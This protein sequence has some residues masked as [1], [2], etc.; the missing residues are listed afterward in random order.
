MLFSDLAKFL[1]DAEQTSGRNDTT[2]KLAGFLQQVPPGEIAQVMYLLQGRLLP[3]FIDLEFGFS[4]KSALKALD[5]VAA[6]VDVSKEYAESGDLGLVAAHI[7]DQVNAQLKSPQS[8]DQVYADLMQLAK[9][10]GKGSQES[11]QQIYLSLIQKADSE[12]ARY[13]TR[14]VLGSLRTGFSD[15]TILD[16]LSWVKS[17]NKSW[18]KQLDIAYGAKAD[19]G[20]LAKLVLETDVAALESRLQQI[21]LTPGVPVAS[22]LV[23]REA[24]AAAV[25]ARMGR[26]LV[27]PK[28]DGLRCQIHLLAEP[29]VAGHRVEI[30]SRNME[31]LTAVFPDVV[32]AVQKLPVQSLIIDSEAIGYDSAEEAYLPFQ[33]TIQRRRKYDI[34][35]TVESIPIRAMAFDLIY[36]DGEDVS[37][38]DVEWRVAQLQQIL[39]GNQQEVICLLESK[40][41][42]TE[43]ELDNYFRDKIGVGLE[44]IIVKRLGTTYDPGTRNFDWIK[45]KA[46]TQSDM[47]DTVDAVVL[48]YFHGRGNRAQF[49]VGALL[50]GVYNSEDDKYYST[51]KIGTG[52]TEAQLAEIFADLQPLVVAT[53]P[54]NVQVA[55][56][57]H[58][59]V[60][61]S[62]QIVVEVDA[63]E[64]TRSPGHT[65][66]QGT[67]A[68]FE[69]QP[70]PKGLSLRFPRLKVWK[71]DKNANQ[72]TTVAELLRLY[73]LRGKRVMG[74]S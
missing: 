44:G 54:Q 16:A 17:G 4:Q 71:R 1:A 61:V 11:K 21:T 53:Q 7:A 24:S 19:I 5:S 59:D 14:I 3:G 67:Q 35:S 46:N 45:L 20:E 33:Q 32:E 69:S 55:K 70:S 12:S 63:D 65:A 57:L 51:A 39:A 64:V 2:V 73:E 52:M 62:P 34:E 74:K 60:W 15:K 10:S 56:P 43:I 48:G 68:A 23:E 30:F 58:P 49:G 47:V 25:F 41:I 29:N 13:I 38:K 26:C 37:R 8:I 42:D 6:G 66:G 40:Y 22:K 50:V 18:R 28:L 31:S 36:L 72:A 27:Q 9:S